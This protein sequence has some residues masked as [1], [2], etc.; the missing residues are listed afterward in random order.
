MRQLAGPKDAEVASPERHFHWLAAHINHGSLAS[1]LDPSRIIRPLH[2]PSLL[3]K[4]RLSLP[5]PV[6]L[7]SSFETI[8]WR[9]ADG[10]ED[11]LQDEPL[12]RDEMCVCGRRAAL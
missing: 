3:S 1:A 4:M 2:L 10:D 12:L 8:P 11:R 6:H 7:S 9:I 5:S